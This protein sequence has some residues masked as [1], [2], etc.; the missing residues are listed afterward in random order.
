M[1]GEVV[2]TVALVPTAETLA[3]LR[4]A[5]RRFT[6]EE[7]ARAVLRAMDRRGHL[8]AADIAT[9]S[10]SGNPLRRR[11]G[12]LARGV[13]GRA[14]LLEGVPAMR[15]GVLRGPSAKYAGPQELG[16]QDLEPDSPYPAITPRPPRKALAMPVGPALT[17]AGVD[18]YGSPLEYPKELTF[19]PWK[20]GKNAVGGLYES[21]SLAKL[22]RKASKAGKAVT[23][24]N[25]RMKKKGIQGPP[26]PRPKVSLR[27]ATLAYVLLRKVGL[28]ARHFIR[29]G[30]D[31]GLPHL[32]NDV[33]DGLLHLLE[34]GPV[35]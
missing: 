19:I 6:K 1:A 31:R 33:E 20:R 30:M 5:Q 9:N 10:L 8:V 2:R 26:A 29:D 15:V 17:P 4:E 12:S 27:E 3:L 23:K 16:T 13:V 32:L 14:E 18:R 25:R 34:E 22:Q 24:S 11:T 35:A 21:E 7:V 28:K